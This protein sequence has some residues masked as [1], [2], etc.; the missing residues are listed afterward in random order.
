MYVRSQVAVNP[1]REREQGED[2]EV[3]VGGGGCCLHRVV[4]ER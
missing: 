3:T 4:S 2:I 1:A